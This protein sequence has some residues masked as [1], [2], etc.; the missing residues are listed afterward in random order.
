MLEGRQQEEKLSNAHFVLKTPIQPPFPAGSAVGI[1][2]TGCYWGT[3]KGFWRMPGV[4]STA[5]GYAG[6]TTPN[7][8]Y[9]ETCSGRTGHTEAVMVIYDPTKLSYADLLKQFYESHNPAQKDGQGGDRGT[10]YR[11]A[12]YTYDDEHLLLAN[13]SKLS[14]E[15][16]L[17]KTIHTEIKSIKEAGPWYY[18]HEAFQQYLA[19]P[20]ARQYCS[21]EP[22]GKPLP[23][24]EEWKPEGVKGEHDHKLPPAYW[25]EHGPKP[26]C[27]IRGPVEQIKWP[28]QL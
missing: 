9:D 17:G 7:P 5:V 1:F 4:L 15:K 23:P 2:A 13:A 28:A 8:T 12:I 10:Q 25:K 3:E 27:A 21:A 14:Y 26:H 20:G 19:R 24:Y 6:G 11:S 16:V 18:A 22:Q